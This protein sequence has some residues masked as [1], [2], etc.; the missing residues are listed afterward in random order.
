MGMQKVADKKFGPGKVMWQQKAID[1]LPPSD[2]WT[3]T[4]V[5]AAGVAGS[6]RDALDSTPSSDGSA[7]H[8]VSVAAHDRS[9]E[10]S[11]G[12]LGGEG[13]LRGDGTFLHSRVAQEEGIQTPLDP[14]APTRE[15]PDR[16]GVT[17]CSCDCRPTSIRDSPPIWNQRV[18]PGNAV[19]EMETVCKDKVCPDYQ[20]SC[21]EK[22]YR[23]KNI[24]DP[25]VLD[26][27]C[28]THGPPVT[29]CRFTGAVPKS[30]ASPA[31]GAGAAATL[32]ASALLLVAA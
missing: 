25:Q 14:L 28:A 32:V 6:F 23:D 1:R 22:Q 7:V 10:A 9:V 29:E 3:A 11:S 15:E 4:K 2:G 17:V 13:S 24:Y 16:G 5:G 31:H 21:R 18:F 20:K 30:G 27:L 19:K 12:A 8:T 26:K